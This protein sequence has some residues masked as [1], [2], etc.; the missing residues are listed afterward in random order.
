MPR[1]GSYHHSQHHV[2][3]SSRDRRHGNDPGDGRVIPEASD[4]A[5]R[6]LGP[7]GALVTA[8][9]HSLAR[10]RLAGTI[11]P[12]TYR[13]YTTMI[14]VWLEWL[15]ARTLTQPA[16]ADVERFLAWGVDQGWGAHTIAAHRLSLRSLYG[17]AARHRAGLDITDGV[18]APKT[19]Y[20][21]PAPLLQTQQVER[22]IAAIAGQ[23][24][25]AHR[26]RLMLALLYGS[27]LEPVSLHRATRADYN[28]RT[29]RLRHQPR[30][31][32]S[33]NTTVQLGARSR[34]LAERYLAAVG[35]LAPQDPLFPAVHST[36]GASMGRALSTLSMRLLV[37]R[38]LDVVYAHDPAVT[39]AP[40]A[41][42]STRRL[43]RPASQALRRSGLAALVSRVGEQQAIAVGLGDSNAPRFRRSV[44]QLVP[45]GASSHAGS[46]A[47]RAAPITGSARRSTTQ[48]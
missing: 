31:A 25:R 48:F 8:W 14:R 44:A 28:A 18:A 22:L 43:Q 32:R 47:R 16:T 1:A 36:T 5:A 6:R 24:L 29:G 19:P 21:A 46:A 45:V 39:A 30:G 4:A 42:R 23:D 41:R 11:A 40:A 37:R 7:T 17:W 27:A 35:R 15:H 20:P 9:E 33:T 12:A 3:I 13:Q 2:R 26:D 38:C 10:R 34:Q